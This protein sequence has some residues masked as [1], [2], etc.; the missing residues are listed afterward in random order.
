[1][2][3]NYHLLRILSEA[4]E[5]TAL[6][7]YRRSV[8]S[9]E[10]SVRLAIEGLGRFA[11][12]RAFQIPQEASRAR[13]LLD[14]GRSVLSGRPY[15]RWTYESAEYRVAVEESLA[16]APPTLVHLGSLDLAGYLTAL[17]R[18][19]VVVDHHNVESQ[20][21]RRRARAEPFAKSLYMRFQSRLMR[22]EESRWTSSASVNLVV[23]SEDER[24]LQAI[25]PGIATLVVPNGVDTTEFTEGREDDDDGGIVFVGGGDWFPNRDAMEFFARRI[26]PRIRETRPDV[27]VCWVGRSSEELKAAFREQG[28]HL[29]GYVDDTRGYVR[30]AQ[31]FVVPLRVGGGS[32]LKILNA[33]SMGRAVVSTSQ[34]CEGLSARQGENILIADSPDSFAESVVR[35]LED[36]ELRR[37]LGTAGRSTAEERYDWRV[38]G[39]DLL[40]AYERLA[41]P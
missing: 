1:M 37:R 22:R 26:L 4:Y 12:V 21:L 40:K 32:R 30:R 11:E 14:H 8:R 20:L 6:C 16:H 2:I 35:V 25:A 41:V 28:V 33:W 36:S 17:P 7:F 18:V 31:C 24:T 27:H 15:T 39:R 23:S 10:A 5:V 9:D 29:T 38:I 13:L 34:G 3:R 19:P